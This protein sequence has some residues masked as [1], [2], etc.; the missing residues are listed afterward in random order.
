MDK[1]LE[2]KIDTMPNK[3]RMCGCY[4]TPLMGRETIETGLCQNCI[5]LKEMDRSGALA[6]NGLCMLDFM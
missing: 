1:E 5:I 4:I 2:R 3:C 6:K